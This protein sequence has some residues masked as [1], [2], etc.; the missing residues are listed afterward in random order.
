MSGDEQIS[1][2]FCYIVE[3]VSE[4]HEI[5]LDKLIGQPGCVRLA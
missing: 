3:L 2:P 4:D 5:D 1:K